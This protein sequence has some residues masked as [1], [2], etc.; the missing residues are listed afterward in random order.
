MAE[1]T[2]VKLTKEEEALQNVTPGELNQAIDVERLTASRCME[3]GQTLPPNYQPPADEDWTT[4]IFGCAED[5]DSC[6][7]GL[8]CP[9]VLFGRNVESLQEDISR[10]SAGICHVVCVEGGMTLAAL[11]SIFYG[12]D[13]N[14]ASNI[15]QGLCFAWWICGIYTGMTRQSLQKKYHLKVL[16]NSS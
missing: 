4:G 11:T 7:T 15:C 9:C 14:T 5:T 10:T 2:Y 6:L 16:L 8:F 13:P 12:V 3:C 1:G